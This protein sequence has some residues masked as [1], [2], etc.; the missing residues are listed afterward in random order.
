MAGQEVIGMP[1]V[2][3]LAAVAGQC[4][5]SSI[6]RISSITVRTT[7]P[8]RSA[9]CGNGIWHAIGSSSARSDDHLSSSGGSMPGGLMV[10]AMNTA[11]NS[12]AVM[13]RA[14]VKSSKLSTSRG[15]LWIA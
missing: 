3:A 10:A 14:P 4:A 1:D 9:S 12:A 5:S 15:G 11:F 8:I 2:G 6:G 7:W 13:M